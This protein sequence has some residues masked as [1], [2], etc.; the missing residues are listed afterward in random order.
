MPDN[1]STVWNKFF[2]H[3]TRTLWDRFPGYYRSLVVETN[4]P[5]NMYRV[6]YKC[7]DMHDWDGRTRASAIGF[8]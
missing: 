8:G 2:K 3:R 4:D 1:I 5:L 7:P 6:R